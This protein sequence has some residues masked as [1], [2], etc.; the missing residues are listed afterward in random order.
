VASTQGTKLKEIKKDHELPI[1]FKLMC[2]SV[3]GAVSQSGILM[4]KS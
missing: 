2:G 1:K 3:A 4:L